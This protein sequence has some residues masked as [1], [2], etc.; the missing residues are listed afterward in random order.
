[1]D[2]ADFNFFGSGLSGLGY[3]TGLCATATDNVV[4][5]GTDAGSS[6][7]GNG[8][9]FI[10][11]HSGFGL[12]ATLTGVGNTF[13]GNQT[14]ISHTTGADCTMVG[15]NA[16]FVNSTGTQNTFVGSNA[17]LSNTI[18]TQNTFIGN[19]A[20]RFNLDATGNTF[21]GHFCG[22]NNSTG[23]ANTGVGQY[24]GYSVTTGA[25]STFIGTSAGRLSN[26]SSNNTFVGQNAGYNLTGASAGGNTAV[27]TAAL[28]TMTTGI[29]NLAFGVS[30][31]RGLT[32]GSQNTF[33][34]YYAGYSGQVDGV[35]NSTAIGRG[36]VTTASNQM[37]FGNASVL[38]NIFNGVTQ[39]KTY[40][41]AGLLSAITTPVAGMRAIVTDAVGPVFLGA[42]TGGGSA[43]TPVF[44]NGTAWVCG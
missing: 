20:G 37:V 41:L 10:G 42:L 31:G 4:A 40:T 28:F 13:I 39:S 32:N 27:G 1:M 9:I 18:G 33:I 44:Y 12:T 3:Q 26:T 15:N 36:A 24:A 8:N 29:E 38:T 34:G 16:G 35:S 22:Y 23:Y 11:Y 6:N 19:S 7:S 5:I 17:G 21:V 2:Y 14:A 25:L 43:T 30:A